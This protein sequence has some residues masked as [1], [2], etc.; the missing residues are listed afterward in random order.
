[1]RD[2]DED[3]HGINTS[4]KL[5]EQFRKQFWQIFQSIEVLET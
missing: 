5:L 3:F 1:M 4:T 2:G